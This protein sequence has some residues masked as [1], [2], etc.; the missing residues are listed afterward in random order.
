[1]QRLLF[2]SLTNGP[3]ASRQTSRTSS[4]RFKYVKRKE[5]VIDL[6][7]KWKFLATPAK[8]TSSSRTPRCILGKYFRIS[9]VIRPTL[10]TFFVILACQLCIR[11]PFIIVVCSASIRRFYSCAQNCTWHMETITEREDGSNHGNMDMICMILSFHLVSRA[12]KD[13]RQLRWVSQWFSARIP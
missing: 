2:V 11:A 9:W 5:L 12:S 6:G 10:R 8:I 7:Q 13:R 3:W 4:S 1:M